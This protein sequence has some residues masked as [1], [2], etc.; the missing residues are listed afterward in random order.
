MWLSFARDATWRGPQYMSSSCVLPQNWEVIC[1]VLCF[2]YFTNCNIISSVRGEGK[3]LVWQAWDV[4]PEAPKAFTANWAAIWQLLKVMTQSC[5]RSLLWWCMMA[6]V[7][8]KQLMIHSWNSLPGSTGPMKPS[9]NSC[10][11]SSAHQTCCWAYQAG[12]AW[13]QALVYQPELESCW[14]WGWKQGDNWNIVWSALPPVAQ[15]CQQLTRCQCK[16]QC[17]GRCKCY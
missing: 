14:K 4:C 13:S 3:K 8:L 9:S 15:S 16:M 6:P 10:S 12:C 5:W 1:G 2:H 7:Q 11:P 17:H